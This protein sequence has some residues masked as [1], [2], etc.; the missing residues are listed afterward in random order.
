MSAN[1]GRVPGNFIVLEVQDVR[2]YSRGAFV[3]PPKNAA[4]QDSQRRTQKVVNFQIERH[5]S[6]KW[7]F[8]TSCPFLTAQMSVFAFF[9]NTPLFFQNCE[10][11]LFYPFLRV[12]GVPEEFPVVLKSG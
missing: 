8:F 11:T 7:L 12:F 4:I 5:R 6:E 10:M 2:N 3:P 9:R 1:D